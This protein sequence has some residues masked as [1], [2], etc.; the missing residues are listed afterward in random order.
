MPGGQKAITRLMDIAFGSPAFY[1]L[2][3]G[4]FGVSVGNA[5]ARRDGPSALA[6]TV[7]TVG[8]GHLA[9]LPAWLL[10]WGYTT[11]TAAVA[12]SLIALL[13][14]CIDDSDA[15]RTGTIG[16]MALAS[17]L[18]AHHEGA[19]P[20]AAAPL[21]DRSLALGSELHQQVETVLRG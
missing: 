10:I 14:R 19:L 5:V 11:L 9:E 18:I 4:G 6:M 2:L 21:G 7:A 17:L 15:F 8:A 20:S 13:L 3:T 12:M 16:T 1:L